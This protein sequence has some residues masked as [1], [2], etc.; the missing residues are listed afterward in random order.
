MCCVQL[1]A[2]L[3]V[4]QYNVGGTVRMEA[5]ASLPYTSAFALNGL[6]K[7]INHAQMAG[8]RQQLTIVQRL[9]QRSAQ[10][11]TLKTLPMHRSIKSAQ[12]GRKMITH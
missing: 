10:L 9:W 2:N 6:G 4:E 8:K 3:H 1:P 12:G 5:G 7:R 11:G